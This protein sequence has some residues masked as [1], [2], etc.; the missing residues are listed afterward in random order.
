MEILFFTR[1][2]GE[3]RQIGRWPDSVAVPQVGGIVWVGRNR[4]SEDHDPVDRRYVVSEVL[5]L[6]RETQDGVL[7]QDAYVYVTLP[8]TADKTA[9]A[10]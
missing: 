2:Q 4:F 6:F 3:E 1:E 5:W 7:R 8:F 9:A 10:E